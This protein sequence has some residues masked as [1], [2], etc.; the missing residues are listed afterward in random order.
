MCKVCKYL[1]EKKGYNRHIKTKKHKAKEELLLLRNQ[2]KIEQKN[3]IL[4]TKN[5]DT[6]TPN[7]I[8]NITNNIQNNQ[9][10][11]VQ[12][13]FSL[14]GKEKVN[15]ITKEKFLKILNQPDI[16]EVISDL[17]RLVYFNKDVPQNNRWCVLYD[18]D[19]YG[20]LQYNNK[21]NKIERWLTS[22]VVNKNFEVMIN[23]LQPVMDDIDT[24]E[25]NSLQKKNLNILYCH[26]GKKN[27][28]EYE[29]NNFKKLMMFA[30]N[31]KDIPMKLWSKKGLTLPDDRIQLKKDIKEI[32][33]IN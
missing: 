1:F 32:N 30:Y 28:S 9:I 4:E 15:H 18:K 24:S 29:P 22:E 31:N 2:L 3:K 26:Y 5:I 16:N 14:L 20:A 11:L 10:F 6:P 17:L 27:I 8:N 33:Y 13:N 21:T 12:N 7:I 23:S 19:E 25:L